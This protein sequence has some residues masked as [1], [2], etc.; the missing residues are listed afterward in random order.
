MTP[1]D[2]N[3]GSISETAEPDGSQN[4]KKREKK[5]FRRILFTGLG[6]AMPPLLTI[7]V[8]LWA[9]H[10][11][12]SYVLVPVE[13]ATRFVAVWYVADIHDDEEMQRAIQQD[14]LANSNHHKDRTPQVYDHENGVTYVKLREKWIPREVFTVVEKDPG[15]TAP[16]TA[17][18]Y[19]NRYV[20]L[21][22]LQRKYVIP[23]FL[24]LFILTL[25]FL[26]RFLA[27]GVGRILYSQFEKVVDN[28]PIVG[29]VYSSVKQVTD[30]AFK[31]QEMQFTRIVA[32]EY[33]RKGVWSM[34]FVTGESFAD[35][36]GAANE[37]VLSVLM[38]TSPM[39]ATG[40]TI[41]V[42]K[43]ETIDLNITMDQALQFCVSCG[44]VVP[45]HQQSNG[46]IEVDVHPMLAAEQGNAEETSNPASDSS[47]G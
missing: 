14:P 29:N 16:D 12:N 42:P 36:R 27:A 47:D 24:L 43:S 37:P 18:S 34:G 11:V 2:S 23:I 8:F 1:A 19:Y 15:D 40:F 9:L 38:P 21:K 28:V 5:S 33:P 3:L 39:P 7:V 45:T 22:Y 32:V 6:F 31:E 35:I 17:S 13:T 26:G 44:V 30:F 20:R 46:T 4:Q 25:C 41:S 10:I